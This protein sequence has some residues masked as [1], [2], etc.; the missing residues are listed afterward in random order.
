MA[1]PIPQGRYSDAARRR[2]TVAGINPAEPAQGQQAGVLEALMVPGAPVRGILGGLAAAYGLAGLS[3]FGVLP[4]VTSAQANSMPGLTPD[5]QKAYEAGQRRLQAGRFGSAAE[6][7]Q[8]EEEMRGLRQISTEFISGRNRASQDEYNRAVTKAETARDAEL[9]RNRRFSDT[10]TGKVWDATG[11]AAPVFAGA[12]AGAVG[13]VASGGGSAIK[14]YLFPMGEGA[15]AG[16]TAANIPLA[17]N[18]FMTEPDNPEKRAYEAYA[19]ELPPEHPRKQEFANYAQGLDRENPV[20]AQAN[21][22]LFDRD[23]IIKRVLFGGLEGAGGALI[24]AGAVRAPGAIAEGI[25][26]LPARLRNAQTASATGA[27]PSQQLPVASP[28]APPQVPPVGPQTA[29]G[30]RAQYPQLGSPQREAIRDAYRGAV[31]DQGAPLLPRDVNRIMQ[32]EAAGSGLTLPNVTNRVANT[33]TNIDSFVAQNGRLPVSR[34]EWD[35][36][37]YRN[38]GTLAVPAAAA[39]AEPVNRLMSLYYGQEPVY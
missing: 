11:G 14:N 6:R 2:A 10:A 18:A 24:G 23:Q 31:L 21:K 36:W 26:G 3:D 20:R 5:Q 33:N 27:M 39:S 29:V 30:G 34:S 1:D 38:T 13:R 4:E 35:Q 17:Y 12:L 9:A 25:A 32:Q 22:E 37:I 16:I 7:R 19:R 8:I 28:V 15:L